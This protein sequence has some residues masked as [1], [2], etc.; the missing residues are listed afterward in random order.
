MSQYDAAPKASFDPFI[1]RMKNVYDDASPESKQEL[2]DSWQELKTAARPFK[3]PALYTALG[4]V[5]YVVVRRSK[6][7]RVARELAAIVEEAIDLKVGAGDAARLQAGLST[8]RF[9][10]TPFGDFELRAIPR[11]DS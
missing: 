6:N 11:V 1:K 10:D 3:K 4:L 5:T 8:L 7:K 9:E 2:K